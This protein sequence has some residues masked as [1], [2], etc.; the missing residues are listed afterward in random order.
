VEKKV[1]HT[2]KLITRNTKKRGHMAK[3]SN[4]SAFRDYLT[5]SKK[6]LLAFLL[7]SLLIINAS[8]IWNFFILKSN[9]DSVSSRLDKTITISLSTGSVQY[10]MAILYNKMIEIKGNRANSIDDSKNDIFMAPKLEGYFMRGQEIR[11]DKG[12][13]NI[14]TV[15]IC[16]IAAQSFISEK[17]YS[18]ADWTTARCPEIVPD[19]NSFTITQAVNT[20]M[21][22]YRDFTLSVASQNRTVIDNLVTSNEYLKFDELIFYYI[23]SAKNLLA[24]LITSIQEDIDKQENGITDNVIIFTSMIILSLIVY[25]A[26]WLT[27]RTK[28]WRRIKYSLLVLNDQL[29]SVDTIK[30]LM[31]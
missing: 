8:S 22:Q 19:R 31:K 15:H 23:N 28:T 27:N 24:E 25:K 30:R 14:V 13:G 7:F 1:V 11:E 4:S 2:L 20:I 17:Y 9:Y 26:I 10:L 5:P 18:I 29:I 3:S 21:L 12:F 6:P 16:D